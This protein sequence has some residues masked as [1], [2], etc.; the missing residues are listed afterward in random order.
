MSTIEMGTDCGPACPI[1]KSTIWLYSVSP[2]D[3]EEYA[4]T[5]VKAR[6]VSCGARDEFG[7]RLAL[8]NV[9]DVRER[10]AELAPYFV[11]QT[12]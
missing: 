8:D 2:E 4:Y 10:H 11:R 12:A 3:L 7:S 5:T 9:A 6:C 1:C